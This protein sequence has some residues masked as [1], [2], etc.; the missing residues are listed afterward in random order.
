[1]PTL[2]NAS[3]PRP[4]SS[5]STPATW[6]PSL[7]CS[8]S[9]T[10]GRS[11]NP[12]V[13]TNRYA[14]AGGD[15]VNGSDPG[16]NE[17]L[18]M[19]RD[20]DTNW[21][22][23]VGRQSFLVVTADD[24]GQFGRSFVSYFKQYE[25]TNGNVPGV[26]RGAKFYAAILS[27]DQTDNFAN[28]RSPENVLFKLTHQSSDI[29]SFEAFLTGERRAD[30]SPELAATLTNQVDDTPTSGSEVLEKDVL[31]SFDR[32]DDSA[33]YQATPVLPG[34][35]YNSNGF[36]RSV[37]EHAGVGNYPTGFGA[38][39]PGRDPGTRTPL[40]ASYFMKWSRTGDRR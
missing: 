20:L 6:T 21:T 7:A 36:A 28:L 23:G 32:Y 2:A 25:N 10:G 19:N 38:A 34:E 17:V 37:A 13:G 18:A 35:G 16:G 30:L 4:A 24:P 15:P 22:L 1:M 12:G 11:P 29:A 31:N 3:T 26:E 14:Y 27:G 33:P 39:M 8:P 5:T 40:P 9:P